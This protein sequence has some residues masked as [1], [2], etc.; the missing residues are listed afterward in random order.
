[1]QYKLQGSKS[2]DQAS[3]MIELLHNVF[4][5]NMHTHTGGYKHSPWMLKSQLGYVCKHQPTKSGGHL[6]LVGCH[7]FTV[8]K[9]I[10]NY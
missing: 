6:H 9:N 10:S 5:L 2:G 4:A 7:V 1:M 8:G 3:L